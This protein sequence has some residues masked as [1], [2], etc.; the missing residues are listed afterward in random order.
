MKIALASALLALA[1]T[2]CAAPVEEVEKRAVCTYGAYTYSCAG[3][4]AT[5]TK[6]ATTT[7][8]AS[9]SA[10]TSVKSAAAASTTAS[11]S[12]SGGKT[13]YSSGDTASDIENNTGCTAL[14]VIFARGTSESGNIGSV[15]GPPMF[16]QLIS[17]L[18]ASDV[19]LQG[20]DYPASASGNADCG[21]DGGADM[22]QLASTILSRCPNTK[23]ALSG[24]SQGAC[25]VHNA[26]KSQGLPASS[27]A[28]VVLF[29]DPFNGQSV[30]SVPSSN[31][32][33]IC[34][35]GDDVCNGSGTYTITQ[36]HLSY[37][38]NAAQ[39]AS[40]IEKTLI[41]AD[42][43]NDG[44]H[45]N[46]N[47]GKM[48]VDLDKHHVKSGHRKA[49]K[50]DNPYVKLLHKLYSF[51]ARRT[52]SKFNNTVLRRLRMSRINRAPIS[53]SKIVGVTANKHSAETYE[54]KI[55][56]VVASVTDDTR[57]YEVPKMTI[58]ALR[59]TATA[60]ARIEKAGGECLT[61]DQLA[62]RAPTGSNVILLRGPKNAREA[63]KHF[64]FGPHTD[65]KPKIESKGRK[66][67][68]ARGRRRSKGFRV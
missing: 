41:E 16:K 35:S 9:P 5:T 2:A 13:A 56:A 20:V 17:D 40:F 47:T 34:A 52:D 55:R 4:V 25:V 21:S 12:S 53:L 27:V 54:G 62:M 63:V 39:A 28:A 57:L 7:A 50:S 38:D 45:D 36:A 60:R 19:T 61:F 11:G 59:F 29:G 49:P 51:L 15:A 10:S 44:P 64:G 66:F 14:T 67:E 42:N 8:K 22:A 30:G 43:D 33:E 46:D 6:A 18:G 23:L 31:L 24:Y 26:V 37:G 48:G 1:L 65:K 3:S 32:L 58:C 68:R